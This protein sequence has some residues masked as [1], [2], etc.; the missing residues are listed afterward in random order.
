MANYYFPPL[1]AP[2]APWTTLVD[3]VFFLGASA[4]MA[5]YYYYF[6]KKDLLGKFWGAMLVAAVGSL[7]VF[8]LFQTF[9]RD[10]IMWLMSPKIGSTQLS[11]VNLIA[12]FIGGFLALYIMNRINHNKERRG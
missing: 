6:L 11:N 7:I 12:I 4:V 8:A 1:G 5:W 2:S 9:I 10:I 3:I